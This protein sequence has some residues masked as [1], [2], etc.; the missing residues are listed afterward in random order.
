M[1]TSIFLPTNTVFSDAVV[2]S[3]YTID[4]AGGGELGA[5]GFAYKI[6]R[7]IYTAYDLSASN[8]VL[9]ISS[10]PRVEFT[11]YYVWGIN[12]LGIDWLKGLVKGCSTSDIIVTHTSSPCSGTPVIQ[13]KIFKSPILTG[14]VGQFAGQSPNANAQVFIGLLQFVAVDLELEVTP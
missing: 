6:E 12:T 9:R 10:F 2:A 7:P 14:M 4:V 5:Y 3:Q 1:P 8:K 11:L 13:K